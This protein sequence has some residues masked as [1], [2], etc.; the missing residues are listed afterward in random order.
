VGGAALGAGLLQKIAIRRLLF[1]CRKEFQFSA[2]G[3]GINIHLER[4][5]NKIGKI[6]EDPP[7]PT[8]LETFLGQKFHFAAASETIHV[9]SL[10]LFFSSYHTHEKSATFFVS[11]FFL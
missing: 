3:A 2:I 9:F 5:R 11:A 4:P 1:L 8:K 7:R 6:S 10:F